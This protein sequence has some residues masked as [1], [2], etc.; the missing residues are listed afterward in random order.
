MKPNFNLDDPRHQL[1]LAIHESQM[2]AALKV[3]QRVED[4]VLPIYW[5]LKSPTKP[6]QIGSGVIVK[7]ESEYFVFSASHIFDSI[8]T[9]QLLIGSGRGTK[10]SSFV[11]DRFSS[12][13]GALG[14][15]FDD[16]IDASVFHIKSEVPEELIQ[17]ALNIEDL[18]F[19][20]PDKRRCVHMFAGFRSKKSRTIGN[21]ANAERECFP[22]VEYKEEVYYK[23][24]LDFSRHIAL[25]YEDKV[26]INGNWQISPTPKGMSGGAI[27]KVDGINF[28]RPIITSLKPKQLL[29]GITI[30]QRREK[31]GKPGVLIGTRINTHLSL[32]ATYLP[33]LLDAIE[34]ES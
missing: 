10:L 20:Q 25:A 24:G 1:A 21:Q 9:S 2:I 8:G 4:A 32:I 15:H 17:V 22:S 11:G 13:K 27:I 33:G 28:S 16:P 18:D 14:T 26:L 6:E 31:S 7:I 30:A 12:A 29:S 3:P 5:T 34:T 23:L 19:S